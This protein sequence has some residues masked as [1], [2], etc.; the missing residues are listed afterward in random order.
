MPQSATRRDLILTGLRQLGWCQPDDMTKFARLLC[1]L[2]YQ[3]R[4][5]GT[6]LAGD[7]RHTMSFEVPEDGCCFNA[8]IQANVVAEN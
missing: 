7:K 4:F 1:Q 3:G 8:S 2:R 5:P 6:R